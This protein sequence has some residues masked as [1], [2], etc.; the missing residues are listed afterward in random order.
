MHPTYAHVEFDEH[1]F[2][3]VVVQAF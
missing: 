1:V 2:S 3:L